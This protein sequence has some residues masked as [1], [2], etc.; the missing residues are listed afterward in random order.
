MELLNLMKMKERCLYQSD[1]CANIFLTVYLL[2][3]IP[4]CFKLVMG[5]IQS[6]AAQYF[7]FFT[8]RRVNFLME[9]TPCLCS[10]GR[11]STNLHKLD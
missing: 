10:I 4:L 1:Q 9:R 2:T 5:V 11:L 7:M 3:K 8:G 6:E